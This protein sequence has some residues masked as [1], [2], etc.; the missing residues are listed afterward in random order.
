MP[1]YNRS[2]VWLTYPCSPPQDGSIQLLFVRR[3][4]YLSHPRHN[5]RIVTR[6]SNEAAILQHLQ[7]WAASTANPSTW[8]VQSAK[9]ALDSHT[10]PANQR[11]T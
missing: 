6:L 3:K 2:R 7:G 9:G 4:D 8:A 11:C 5:G 1:C 10:C